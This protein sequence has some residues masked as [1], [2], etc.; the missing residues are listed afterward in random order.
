MRPTLFSLCGEPVDARGRTPLDE[1]VAAEQRRRLWQHLRELD[2]RDY[3]ALLAR[4]RLHPKH[5]SLAS[6][7]AQ[8]HCTPQ[9]VVHR[10]TRVARRLRR[11]LQT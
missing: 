1:L 11:K 7:A 9:A 6:L 10:A 8:W 5:S 2:N 4:A 3:E